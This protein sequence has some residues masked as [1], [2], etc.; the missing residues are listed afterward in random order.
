MSLTLVTKP[1][2]EPISVDIAKSHLRVTTNNDDVY[3]EQLIKEVRTWTEGFLRRA[4]ITQ[5]WDW[6]M[7]DGFPA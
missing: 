6:K 1:T 3:I 5:T 4:L 2:H 7:D